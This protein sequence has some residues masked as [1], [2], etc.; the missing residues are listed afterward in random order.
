MEKPV[1]EVG[2][3]LRREMRTRLSESAMLAEM[4]SRGAFAPLTHGQI[5]HVIGMSTMETGVYHAALLS[6]AS[7]P[8]GAPANLI[9]WFAIPQGVVIGAKE[10]R[11]IRGLLCE[12]GTIMHGLR[13]NR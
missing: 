2:E 12:N 1:L 9:Y 11:E 6:P 5:F 4:E 3:V 7:L 10:V 13:V 8:E